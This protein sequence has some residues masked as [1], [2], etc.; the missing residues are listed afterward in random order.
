MDETQKAIEI[1]DEVNVTRN[2]V[3]HETK[4]LQKL[5]MQR[6]QYKQAKLSMLK[7]RGSTSTMEFES[8]NTPNAFESE[9]FSSQPPSRP[10]KINA[11]SENDKNMLNQ[12]ENQLKLYLT[13]WEM[14]IWNS[15]GNNQTKYPATKALGCQN[16]TIK[17][18]SSDGFI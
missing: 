2:Q 7:P 6:Q 3:S 5:E 12:L 17:I 15:I 1:Q 11:W 9:R 4:R 18:R 8:N 10:V 16:K 13:K 14:V